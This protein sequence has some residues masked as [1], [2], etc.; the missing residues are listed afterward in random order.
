MTLHDNGTLE[1]RE[2]E[3][4]YFWHEFCRRPVCTERHV[5]NR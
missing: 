3:L 4:L 5:T 2:H 1:D